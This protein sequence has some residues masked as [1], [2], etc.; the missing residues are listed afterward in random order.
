MPSLNRVTLMGNLTRDPAVKQIST[1][2]SVA[3]F[4]LAINRKWFD[5]STNAAKEECTFVDVAAWGKL[6]EIAE[7]YL[8]KGRLVLIEGRLHL[9]TWTDKESQQKRSKM[10]VI[11]ENLTLL[12][13]KPDGGHEHSEPA[14]ESHSASDGDEIP[15]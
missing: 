4:S 10:K 15:F 5:K 2:T 7:K 3:E 14:G 11:A 13:S 1:G 12:G 8:A 6:A 9:E